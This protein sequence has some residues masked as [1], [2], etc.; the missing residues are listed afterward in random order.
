MRNPNH[1]NVG[2]FVESVIVAAFLVALLLS[3][4]QIYDNCV[5]LGIV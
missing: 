1:F 5:R 3:G 2:A 4:L